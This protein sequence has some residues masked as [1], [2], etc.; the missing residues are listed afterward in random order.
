VSTLK[1]WTPPVDFLAPDFSTDFERAMVTAGVHPVTRAVFHEIP[2]HL[3]G[4][5]AAGQSQV[6]FRT[7][8]LDNAVVELAYSAPAAARLSPSPSMSVV[9]SL[10]PELATIPTDRGVGGESAGVGSLV[11]QAWESLRFKLDYLD[12]EGLRGSLRV[13]DP[14]LQG[15]CHT[16]LLGRHKYLPYRKWFRKELA[17]YVAG[18]VLASQSLG[19]FLHRNSI[20]RLSEEHLS[21]RRNRLRELNVVLTLSAVERMVRRQPT[22]S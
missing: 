20:M 2:S 16:P 3:Y 11:H 4:T 7:P 14:I 6:T 10:R 9:Q 18:E 22:I 19:E 12:K 5:F 21:G 13:L 17:A 1:A 15:L 8:Y